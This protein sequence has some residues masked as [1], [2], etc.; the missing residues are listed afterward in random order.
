MLLRIDPMSLISDVEPHERHSL[1]FICICDWIL[2]RDKTVNLL[3]ESAQWD[4]AG[5]LGGYDRDEK[6]MLLDQK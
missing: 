3:Y 2:P 6:K 1:F 5:V 4:R